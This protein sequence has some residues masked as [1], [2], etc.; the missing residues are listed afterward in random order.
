M[1]N[2]KH[3]IGHLTSSIGG[4]EF[5]SYLSKYQQLEPSEFA[6]MKV[7]GDCIENSLE[8]IIM[9]ISVLQYLKLYPVVLFGWGEPLNKKLKEKGIESKSI[10]GNR[11]TDFETLGIIKEVVGELKGKIFSLSKE[12]GLNLVDLTS[13]HIFAAKKLSDGLGYVGEPTGVNLELVKKACES[14]ATPLLVPLGYDGSQIYNINA[15]TAAKALVMALK[16][17]K[18][19]SITGIGGVLDKDQKLIEKISIIDDYQ[20]LADEGVVSGG[21]LKKLNEA[22]SLLEKL[23]NKNSVQII[24]PLLKD[25]WSELFSYKGSGTKIIYGYNTITCDGLNGID[26]DKLK[27]LIE[28]AFKGKKLIDNYFGEEPITHIVLEEDYDGTA[29]IEDHKGWAYMD[30]FAVNKNTEG[31]GLGSKIFSELLKLKNTGIFSEKSGLFWRCKI[32]N[33]KKEMY[34]KKIEENNGSG[35]YYSK[36]FIVFWIGGPKDELHDIID[37]ALNKEETLAAK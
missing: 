15:D 3:V 20:K 10:E 14:K 23:G 19:I 4:K 30:K 31:N 18:C 2:I 9:S 13:E 8:E 28:S 32:D 7:S 12:Y 33:D 1:K 37:Y 17:H 6:V 22:K 35:C 25:L 36:P 11:V 34:K 26:K 5:E 21:M 16:P 29:I 27:S 24:S